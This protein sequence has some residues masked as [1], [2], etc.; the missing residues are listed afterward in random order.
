MKKTPINPTGTGWA[1][2]NRVENAQ[3]LVFVSGQGPVDA[4][5]HVPEDTAEQI[6]LAWGN[7]ETQLKDA[8]LTLANLTKVT[9]YLTDRAY[10]PE[11]ISVRKDVLG[12]EIAPTM[13]LAL[14]GLYDERWKVEIEAIAVA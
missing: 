9:T 7:V 1:Q 12:L 6:R 10:I 5:G 3:T 8:G 4:A 13:T 2:T 14:C 11:M